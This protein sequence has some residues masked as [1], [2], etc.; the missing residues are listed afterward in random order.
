MG[1]DAASEAYWLKR[2]PVLVSQH[3]YEENFH[4]VAFC[5]FTS[6]YYKCTKMYLDQQHITFKLFKNSEGYEV[7]TVT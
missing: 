6:L 4:F 7:V 2:D 3:S 5:Y 1:G